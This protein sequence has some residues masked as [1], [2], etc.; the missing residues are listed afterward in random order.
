M[1]ALSPL[2]QERFGIVIA[3][4]DHVT[5]ASLGA[6]LEFCRAHRVRMLIARCP[7]DEIGAAQELER[8]G[9]HLMDTLVRYERAL[10][11]DLAL[12][13]ACGVPV[14]PFRPDDEAS[15]R[16]V[17]EESFH[18]YAGHYH[19]DP[20]LDRARVAEVY[21][22]WATR[23]CQSRAVAGQVLI[24]DD[25]DVAG[26]ATLRL[27]DPSEGE[28]VLFAVAPRAR[29]LGIYRAFM[30]ES[31]HWCRDSGAA[32]MVVSTQLT[33]LVVQ[34]VWIALG[35]APDRSFYTFHVWFPGT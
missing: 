7:S 22:S 33:N 30:I 19:A 34:K 8:A 35:F 5:R 3:R 1:I 9:G 23:S 20:M 13:H 10:G 32:R 21:P 27:N 18:D 12:E 4:D 29:G 25:G 16:R 31:M 26:F 11:R 17:A 28:G 6:T 14:R 15:V 24:A 2:D